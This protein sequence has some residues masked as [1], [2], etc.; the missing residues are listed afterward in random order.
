MTEDA[1]TVK[2]RGWSR[3]TWWLVVTLVMVV[4]MG[5][6]FALGGRS[7]IVPAKPNPA[8]TIQLNPGPPNDL[9]RLTDPT[10]FVLP[11]REGFS[12]RAWLQ[13]VS[14]TNEPFTWIEPEQWLP[15]AEAGLGNELKNFVKTNVFP[16][17]HFEIFPEA[18]F[19]EPNVAPPMPL[20]TASTMRVAGA[21]S[22]RNILARPELPPIVSTNLLSSSV[23][24]VLV[25]AGGYTLSAVLLPPG[26]GS[27]NADAKAIDLAKAVRFAPLAR[28]QSPPPLPN[29]PASTVVGTI[30]FDWQIEWPETSATN[31][32]TAQ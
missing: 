21:L 29:A 7:P 6:I 20:V 5:F 17:V 31:A 1:L 10:L 27:A 23:V 14:P 2:S 16:A 18:E 25:D 30:I 8:P 24:Q 28:N 13:I 4:Q 12:G 11:H 22:E 26:S 15:L 19:S 32:P 9:L 3:T